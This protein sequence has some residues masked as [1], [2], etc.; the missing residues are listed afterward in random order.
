MAK[1]NKSKILKMMWQAGG[2]DK[3]NKILP[4]DV[5]AARDG[6]FVSIAPKYSTIA[7]WKKMAGIKG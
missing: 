3:F 5:P 1:P 4:K 7:K 6:V 2:P